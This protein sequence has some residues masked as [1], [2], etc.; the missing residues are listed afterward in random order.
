[1]NI[2]K[3]VKITIKKILIVF[4]VKTKFILIF[5]KKILN[6][7]RYLYENKSIFPFFSKRS[8]IDHF[9]ITHLY[10]GEYYKK[11]IT[12]ENQK[13]ISLKTL[14]NGQGLYWAKHYYTNPKAKLHRENRS[15]IYLETEKFISNYN[16]NQKKNIFVNF[17]SSSG[18]DLIYIFL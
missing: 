8:K 2:S 18:L 9:I 4:F 17:G 10:F 14:S 7:R 11:H 6:Y 15:T 1:M 12:H 3:L 5:E 16:L 13:K